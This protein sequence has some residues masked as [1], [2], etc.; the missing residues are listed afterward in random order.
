VETAI[1][2]DQRRSL[3]VAASRT[4]V[5]QNELQAVFSNKFILNKILYLNRIS[6]QN[7]Y[8]LYDS[9]LL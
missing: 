9:R 4:T 6:W 7:V 3:T 5:K 1:K 2:A 8:R